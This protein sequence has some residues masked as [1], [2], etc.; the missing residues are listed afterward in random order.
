[1]KNF[2]FL[3]IFICACTDKP[4]KKDYPANMYYECIC[5]KV[6]TDFY[7]YSGKLATYRKVKVIT[8]YTFKVIGTNEIFSID[9]NESD[10]EFKKDCKYKFD[11]FFV[12]SKLYK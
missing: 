6:K 4:N 8:T 7:T 10:F 12:D 5:I 2:I 3:T 9:S 1:M 11:P